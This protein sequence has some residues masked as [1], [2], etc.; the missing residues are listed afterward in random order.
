MFETL[1]ADIN[2]IWRGLQTPIADM[3]K[4]LQNGVSFPR[5][6]YAM[7]FDGGIV[8]DTGLGLASGD[9]DYP[10]F[11]LPQTNKPV[12]WRDVGMQAV[13]VMQ[14][15][16][17][18]P[19]YADPRAV[20][21]AVVDKLRAD[22]LLPLM[23]VELEFYLHDEHSPISEL[24]SSEAISRHADFLALLRR[25]AAAQNIDLGAT[26]S[27]YAP[28]QFEINLNHKAPLAACL[29]ALLF[30]R[31]VRECARTM[32]RS[33]TFM[34]KPRANCSGSGMHLHLSMQN[35]EFANR[36]T[37]LSATAGVMALLSEAMAFFAPFGNS[38]RRYVA[39]AYAPL[40]ACWD[41]DN[42]N[43]AVRLPVAAADGDKRMEL[44]MPGADANPYLAAAALLAG[45]HWGITRDMSPT[46]PMRQRNVP[47]T[48]QAALKEFGRGKILP[49]YI[50]RRF[51]RLYWH[52]KT[53][54]LRQETAHISD[55]DR[56]F[57]GRVL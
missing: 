24:Y 40:A 3:D 57:Y 18:A 31:I 21:A 5:S 20:L 19:F 35:G 9:P 55:Y 38:Y 26:T 51:L 39:G 37:L 4:T 56:D 36:Q 8:E 15:P 2:G 33:A 12:A 42:R 32:G 28:G 34:A 50:D 46:K 11:F 6:L 7:R 45:A 44:R 53:D 29:E 13:A 41:D 47:A 17:G 14:T 10:C 25:A 1:I 48:W 43:A 52:I 30:R 23:A 49:H 16:D 22:G 54:E 27:E